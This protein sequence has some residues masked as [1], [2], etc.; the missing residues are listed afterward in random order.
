MVRMVDLVK[1]N[2]DRKRDFGKSASSSRNSQGGDEGGISF[3]AAS[4]SAGVPSQSSPVSKARKSVLQG[5]GGGKSLST[6]TSLSA[7]TKYCPYLGGRKNRSKIIDYPAASNVCYGEESREKKLLRTIILPFSL[8]PA[9]RQREF[10]LATF[11]RCPLY[12]AQEKEKA[13]NGE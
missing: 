1:D 2:D 7:K 10:C 8:V 6:P 5:T 11:R 3:V 13:E 4:S 12:L 9:P